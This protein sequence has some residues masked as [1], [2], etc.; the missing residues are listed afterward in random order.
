MLQISPACLGESK[1]RSSFHML[2]RMPRMLEPR[3]PLGGA[4]LTE[5]LGGPSSLTP[6]RPPSHTAFV[7]PQAPPA[8]V[9]QDGPCSGARGLLC[10]RGWAC[11][12]ITEV[13]RLPA[14]EKHG[15]EPSNPSASH[16]VTP[17]PGTAQPV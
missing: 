13:W 4:S 10:H 15:K 2:L 16:T 6:G 12:V 7:V 3:N 17:A 8:S 9:P 5:V 14:F 11:P 1:A